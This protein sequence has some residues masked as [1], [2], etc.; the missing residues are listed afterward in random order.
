MD[1]VFSKERAKA[2]CT[3]DEYPVIIFVAWTFV[4]IWPIG[5]WVGILIQMFWYNVPQVAARK[6]HRAE[7]MMFMRH[8]LANSKLH[9]KVLD[10]SVTQDCSLADLT[11]RYARMQIGKQSVH[12]FVCQ[13]S[14]RANTRCKHGIDKSA[15]C[16][17]Y[18][19]RA[20]KVVPGLFGK[21]CETGRGC[22]DC[23][24]RPTSRGADGMCP[25]LCLLH[26]FTSHMC[27]M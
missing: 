15:H 21:V 19:R 25:L 2:D 1:V 7:Q 8:L 4:A 20:G 5:A 12:T 6:V 9:G 27:D 26:D 17:R 11:D 18:K 14:S 10:P 23:P 3:S 13:Y 22:R 24:R 16:G